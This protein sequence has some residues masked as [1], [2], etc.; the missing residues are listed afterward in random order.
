M[1]EGP[2]YFQ[3]LA[4]AVGWSW[5]VECFILGFYIDLSVAASGSYDITIFLRKVNREIK[6]G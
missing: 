6:D 5:E 2:K 4:R 3:L 1:Q